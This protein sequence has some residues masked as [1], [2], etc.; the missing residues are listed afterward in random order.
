[1]PSQFYIHVQL[2]VLLVTYSQY[3]S[4]FAYTFTVT[5]HFFLYLLSF[6]LGSLSFC[7]RNILYY[8][9]GAGLLV[10][11]SLNFCRSENIFTSSIVWVQ[12]LFLVWEGKKESFLCGHHSIVFW[13]SLF[14][15]TSQLLGAAYRS[16]FFLGKYLV[17]FFDY[18]S[19]FFF[20]FSFQPR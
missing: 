2:N 8:F 11:N 3:S 12:N 19:D 6:H 1:M 15:L 7:V 16:S 13:L 5:F 17:F 14:Q 9:L 4:K 20:V 10:T 18:F